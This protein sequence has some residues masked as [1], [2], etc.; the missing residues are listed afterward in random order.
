MQLHTDK[1]FI[2]SYFMPESANLNWLHKSGAK[3]TMKGSIPNF[4]S[5]WFSKEQNS[6]EDNLMVSTYLVTEKLS[7]TSNWLKIKRNSVYGH[8]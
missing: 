4:Q 1:N 7:L 2:E 3:N 8:K 5:F 6:L